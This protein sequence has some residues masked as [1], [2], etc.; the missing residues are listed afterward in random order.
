YQL[1]AEDASCVLYRLDRVGS[2]VVARAPDRADDLGA[3]T[4]HLRATLTATGEWVGDLAPRVAATHERV[5]A[6]PDV[7]RDAFSTVFARAAAAGGS[8]AGAHL[9]GH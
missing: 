7:L 5:A 2:S 6:I 9:A 8:S 1:A 3:Q 4:E